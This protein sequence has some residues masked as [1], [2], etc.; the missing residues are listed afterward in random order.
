MESGF[1]DGTTYLVGCHGHELGLGEHKGLLWG[2][3]NLRQ[4]SGAYDVQTRLI[5]VHAGQDDLWI[6][7]GIAK[8]WI[9][10]GSVTGD[11]FK[12]LSALTWPLLS[13]VLLV[14]LTL[15]KSM[16]CACQ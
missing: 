8:G 7:I 12:A 4:I 10:L 1:A 13:S 16:G 6:G 15:L 2:P 11:D 9:G 5:L 14:S 3:G